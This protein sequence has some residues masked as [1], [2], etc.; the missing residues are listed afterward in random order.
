MLLGK[1]VLSIYCR[2]LSKHIESLRQTHKT[3][4]L[5]VFGKG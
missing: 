2:E 3:D 4:K 5:W 1:L